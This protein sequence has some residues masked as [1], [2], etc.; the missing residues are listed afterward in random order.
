MAAD[1]HAFTQAQAA[2]QHQVGKGVDDGAAGQH[3]HRTGRPA[4][5]GQVDG[6]QVHDGTRQGAGVDQLTQAAGGGDVEGRGRRHGAAV[7]QGGQGPAN[8][9]ALRH[10]QQIGAVIPAGE[11]DAC[12]GRHRYG[13]AGVIGT[14]AAHHHRGGGTHHV[15]GLRRQA[16]QADPGAGQAGRTTDDQLGAVG[17]AQAAARL[18]VVAGDADGVGQRDAGAGV[19]DRVAGGIDSIVQQQGAA[20]EDHIAEGV[21]DGALAVGGVTGEGTDGAAVAARDGQAAIGEAV[22]QGAVDDVARDQ[23][24]VHQGAD[25]AAEDQRHSLGR[26]DGAAVDHRAHGELRLQDA[27]LVA[28]AAADSDQPAVQHRANG[29][30]IVD[31]DAAGGGRDGAAVADRGDGGVVDDAETTGAQGDPTTIGQQGGHAALAQDADVRQDGA[32]VGHRADGGGGAQADAELGGAGAHA[33]I[34]QPVVDQRAD[35]GGTHIYPRPHGTGGKVSPVDQR[36]DGSAIGDIG[37]DAA[38]IHGAGQR[39]AGGIGTDVVAGGHRQ[40]VGAV[41]AQGGRQRAEAAVHHAAQARVG[42]AGR[43]HQGRQ[44]VAHQVCYP[45][46]WGGQRGDDAAARH[47]GRTGDHQF[48]ARLQY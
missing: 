45:R 16:A 3:A 31:A 32:G 24:R 11:G 22:V 5:D 2:G 12:L 7:G 21:A 28:G 44:R 34:D 20:G 1:V 26:Q 48:R 38:G 47:G 30:D 4:H 39:Q 15:V 29:P 42:A 27:V 41:G 10:Q 9:V 19:D 6:R 43:G 46:R 36:A 37:R 14:G 13:G 35:G 8:I 18:G 17:Q 23:A 33:R 40:Q 25:A